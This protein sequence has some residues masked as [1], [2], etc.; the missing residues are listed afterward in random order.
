MS[1]ANYSLSYIPR[2]R[3][4]AMRVVEKIGN[5]VINE[6]LPFHTRRR[7]IKKLLRIIQI[8]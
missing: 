3:R 4:A 8:T 2:Q 5:G 7:L 6:T 1:F